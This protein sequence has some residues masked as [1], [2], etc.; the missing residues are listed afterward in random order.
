MNGD[1]VT[2]VLRRISHEILETHRG[3]SGV[4]LVGIHTRGAVLAKLLGE[5]IGDFESTRVPVGALDIGLYRD[6]RELRGDREAVGT[7]IPVDI[8]GRHVVIVDDVLYTGRT[9][10]ASLD[11]LSDIGR[12]LT[13]ELAV[14]VD[15]GHRELPI[16]ADYVGKNVPTSREERVRVHLEETDGDM[17]VYIERVKAA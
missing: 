3:A 10:R 8:T 11:A 15:R 6:D 4:V 16:R 13:T 5:I 17:G 2:R 9:V 1:D 7:E 14:L 12:A